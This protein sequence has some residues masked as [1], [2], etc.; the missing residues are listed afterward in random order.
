T[1][2]GANV[3]NMGV[4][5]VFIGYGIFL[6]LRRLLPKNLTGFLASV[7]VASWFSVVLASIACSL[8]LAVSGTVPLGV[9]LP[10]MASVHMIIGIGEA[11]IT[12]AIVAAVLAAR[13]DLVKTFTLPIETVGRLTGQPGARMSG[14]SRFW[15]FVAG[16]LA[17]AVALAVFVSPFASSSPDGLERVA[18]DK[19][20]ESAAAEKPVWSF[21]PLSDYQIPGIDN[22]KLATAIA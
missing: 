18:A 6:L 4:V 1:A 22:E 9:A 20:F 11:L 13:P 5:G 12:T 2:L 15:A 10:A 14:R 19:G 3:F 17:V 7:A 21:A 16:A 8:E